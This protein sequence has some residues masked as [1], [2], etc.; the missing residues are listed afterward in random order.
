MVV[1]VENKR[2][3]VVTYQCT[4]SL[5]RYLKSIFY[6]MLNSFSIADT[7]DDLVRI[8]IFHHS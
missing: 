7:P 5:F 8:V 4:S 1:F 6:Y 3:Y 2:G